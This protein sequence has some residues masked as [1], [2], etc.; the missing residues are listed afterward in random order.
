M[1]TPITLP[2]VVVIG[3]SAGG[4]E[5]LSTL[6]ATLPTPFSAPIVIAQHLD[7]TRPSHL[8][9]V[10]ARRSTLPLETAKDQQPLE[11]GHIYLAPPTSR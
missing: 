6:V 8:E 1:A 10:L 3:A 7:P 9:E 5:A 11:A 4:V 2:H